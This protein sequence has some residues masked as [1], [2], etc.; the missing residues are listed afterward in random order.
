MLFFF[1]G[2]FTKKYSLEKMKGNNSLNKNANFGF[3]PIFNIVAVL[4]N[5]ISNAVR[6][7]SITNTNANNI[8]N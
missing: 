5:G 1:S 4:P 8:L 6:M 2:K 7:R 3:V